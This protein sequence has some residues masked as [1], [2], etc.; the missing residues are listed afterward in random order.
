MIVVLRPS[1]SHG[2]DDRG[3]SPCVL[4]EGVIH[5]PRWEWSRLPPVESHELIRQ[6]PCGE[7]QRSSAV[8]APGDAQVRDAVKEGVLVGGDERA[9]V[10][11]S[12]ELLDEVELLPG[13]RKG[14]RHSSFQ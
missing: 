1:L 4:P 2:V 5:I 7:C 10:Q 8:V 3:L 14:M 13:R 11:E 9:L 6:I 12:P